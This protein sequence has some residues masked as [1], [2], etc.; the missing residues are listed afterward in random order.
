MKSKGG[1]IIINIALMIAVLVVIAVCVH[2]AVNT[3]TKHGERIIVPDLIGTNIKS[4]KIKLNNRNLKMIIT[5]SV[6]NKHLPIGMIIKQS[7]KKNT[8]VK[9]DREIYV[10]ISTNIAEMMQIP[11]IIDNS[12]YRSAEA[13]LINMGFK[14]NKAHTI[15][16]EKDWVYG[17]KC[18]GRNV[19]SGDYVSTENRLTLVIGNGLIDSLTN[20]VIEVDANNWGF[21]DDRISQ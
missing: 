17:L 6:Y 11:D 9:P 16:G 5:D 2:F 3:Y 8:R 10:T 15:A 12:S 4:A 19:Y 14:L 18:N 1:W 13:T 7:P 21:E 20:D